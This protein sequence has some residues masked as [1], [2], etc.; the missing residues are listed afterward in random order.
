[1]ASKSASLVEMA[2]QKPAAPWQFGL[3]AADRLA[4]EK[5]RDFFAAARGRPRVMAW[6]SAP[7]V[8]DDLVTRETLLRAWSGGRPLPLAWAA[9][10]ALAMARYAGR[11]ADVVDLTPA[12]LR[13]I[14]AAAA[15]SVEPRRGVPL[16]PWSIIFGPHDWL[17]LEAVKE[18][19][20]LRYDSQALRFAIQTAAR[21]LEDA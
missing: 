4:L 10:R 12:R 18:R 16:T 19:H 3:T 2:A 8:T 1:M 9:R 14:H 13:E 6:A 21:M 11:R 15:A 20:G 7:Q 17:D 5:I